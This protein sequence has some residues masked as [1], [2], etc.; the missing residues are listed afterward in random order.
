VKQSAE[1][2]RA[3]C[4][5]PSP[6]HQWTTMG[7]E[8]S[9]MQDS[10]LSQTFIPEVIKTLKIWNLCVCVCVRASK[11]CAARCAAAVQLRVHHS[12]DHRPFFHHAKLTVLWTCRA[13]QFASRGIDFN[14]MLGDSIKTMCCETSRD[15]ASRR[16]VCPDPARFTSP[17]RRTSDTPASC[18]EQC[19]QGAP[20]TRELLP[21]RWQAFDI[22][23]P[24]EAA[25]RR[26]ASA[27]RAGQWTTTR[28]QP[29]PLTPPVPLTDAAMRVPNSS[30]GLGGLGQRPPSY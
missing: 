2:C 4:Q 23:V 14:R 9:T 25:N 28:I 11:L 27:I 24:D 3:I 13:A 10:F 1:F 19:Q 29:L 22:S 15:E 20:C 5:A 6:P 8:Q 7:N 17:H 30:S 18:E 21:P 16:K 12:Q 26:E